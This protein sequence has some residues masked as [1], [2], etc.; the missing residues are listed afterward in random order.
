MTTTTDHTPV[1]HLPY[2]KDLVT[3]L[4]YAESELRERIVTAIGAGSSCWE[5]LA[6]AGVFESERAVEVANDLTAHV[7]RLTN[8]GEPALGCATTAQLLDELR[9]RL[10]VG[11]GG[12]DYRP[13]D[14]DR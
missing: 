3:R 13:V 12:L 9:T 1:E 5:N 14:E 6:G 10:E 11:L 2:A 8:L 4:P 7:L